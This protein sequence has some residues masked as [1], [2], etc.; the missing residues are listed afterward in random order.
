MCLGDWWPSQVLG[1][2]S[3]I[4]RE[5]VHRFA[6]SYS[7]Y[8]FRG[9]IW[10]IKESR[11]LRVFYHWPKWEPQ[12]SQPGWSNWPCRPLGGPPGLSFIN[13]HKWTQFRESWSAVVSCPSGPQEL[14]GGW[15]WV[16]D[17]IHWVYGSEN[18][19]HVNRLPLPVSDYKL[20]KYFLIMIISEKHLWPVLSQ[21]IFL[22]DEIGAILKCACA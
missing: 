15:K 5:R 3:G 17:L 20:S 14:S 2:L 11:A 21:Q 1:S 13:T 12:Q 4:F 6:G 7:H 10:F 18:P 22:P 19:G 16:S 9:L 8:L